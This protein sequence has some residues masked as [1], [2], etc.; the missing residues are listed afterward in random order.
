MDC[1]VEFVVGD[2][3]DLVGGVCEQIFCSFCCC[4]VEVV[5]FV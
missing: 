4:M 3:D 5:G 2:V 1:F